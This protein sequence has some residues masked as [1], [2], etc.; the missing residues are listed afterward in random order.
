MSD[1]QAT[2]PHENWGHDESGE[3]HCHDCKKVVPTESVPR[4]FDYEAQ[5]K[6]QEQKIVDSLL[7]ATHA[8]MNIGDQLLWV[9]IEDIAEEAALKF[10]IPAEKC[11]DCGLETPYVQWVLGQGCSCAAAKY[12]ASEE[13]R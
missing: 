5:E 4:R 10:G 6:E 12:S 13:P 9:A 2:C 7:D 1:D 11:N 8:A 3:A